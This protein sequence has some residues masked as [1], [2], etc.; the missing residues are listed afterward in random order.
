MLDE[1]FSL[2]SSVCLMKTDKEKLNP[3]FLK[4]Y[5]Q[6]PMGFEKMTGQMTGAAIKRIILKTIKASIIPVPPVIDQAKFVIQFDEL[7]SETQKLAEIYQNKL[8]ALDELKKS[9]LQ[10]AF[11]GELTSNKNKGAAA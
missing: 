2:L 5:I 4:Y 7:L 6:S 3:A 1:P 9:I 10:K 8:N 11:T